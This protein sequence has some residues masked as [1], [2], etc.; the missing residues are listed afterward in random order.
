MK[1]DNIR[2]II[3]RITS[4]YETYNPEELIK[5]MGIKVENLPNYTDINLLKGCYSMAQGKKL[6][7]IHPDLDDDSRREVLAHEFGHALLHPTT[8]T[9]YLANCTYFNL[10][11]LENEAD[12]FAAELL[13]NDNIFEKYK[14][15]SIEFIASCEH[16]PVRFVELKIK[17]LKKIRYS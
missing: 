14:G 16:V 2:K 17:N 10:Q 1:V 13:L 7:Q 8:N 9:F 11:K 12:T 15:K 6:I 5:A 3:R 4:Y